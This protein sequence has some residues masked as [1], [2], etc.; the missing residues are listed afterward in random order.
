MKRVAIAVFL[1]AILAGP[2]LAGQCPVDMKKIDAVLAQNPQIS[3]AQLA[4]V[5]E[6]RAQGEV[7]HKGR[8]HG[9]SVKTLAK[10]KEILGIK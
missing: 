9:A 7:Q 4:E 1:S 3:A 2:A 6:L 5:T 10:A 8:Q